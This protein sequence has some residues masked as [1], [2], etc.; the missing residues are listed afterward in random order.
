MP[1]AENK[2]EADSDIQTSTEFIDLPL[3]RVSWAV[4]PGFQVRCLT[5]FKSLRVTSMK[6]TCVRFKSI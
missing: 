2:P 1:V 3:W 6:R 5:G 4:V